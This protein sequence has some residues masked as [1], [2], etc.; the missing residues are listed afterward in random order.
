MPRGD[1]R[2]LE[3]RGLRRIPV[4]VT[5]SAREPGQPGHGREHDGRPAEAVS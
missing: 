5:Q 1:D 4:P 3:A 2:L